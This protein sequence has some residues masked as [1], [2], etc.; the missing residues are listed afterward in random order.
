MAATLALEEVV[1]FIFMDS[2][3]H[4]KISQILFGDKL[5]ELIW[6]ISNFI[7]MP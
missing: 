1:N 7:F 2:T 3:N 6:S 4:E 5:A